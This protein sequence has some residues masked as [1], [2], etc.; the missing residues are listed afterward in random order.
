MG[1]WAKTRR[2]FDALQVSLAIKLG[3]LAE[4]NLR[5]TKNALTQTK[6]LET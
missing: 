2:A 1:E 4:T 3:D 5:L 6:E